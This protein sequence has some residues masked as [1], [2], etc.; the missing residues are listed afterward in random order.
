MPMTLVRPPPVVRT[1]TGS[2]RYTILAATID[3][4]ELT[5][6]RPSSL[7]KPYG[8]GKLRPHRACPWRVSVPAAPGKPKF[9]KQELRIFL[10]TQNG[11]ED[12]NDSAPGHCRYAPETL[13]AAFA[14][15]TATNN[16]CW[17]CQPQPQG[18]KEC[19]HTT[20][21]KMKR[22][23]HPQIRFNG[24]GAAPTTDQRATAEQRTRRSSP[25]G[26]G[27][28][29]HPRATKARKKAGNHSTP[30]EQSESSK[31]LQALSRPAV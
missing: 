27:T 12:L 20:R 8:M 26:R 6:G 29:A 18:S 4:G 2:S 15:E 28:T 11:V 9:S 16:P 5:Q 10:G 23:R 25:M 19:K 1:P 30:A 3:A 22:R 7:A 14:R 17:R 13:D 24:A 31:P 21:R